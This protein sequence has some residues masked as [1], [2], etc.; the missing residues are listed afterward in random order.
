MSTHLCKCLGH[1]QM[2]RVNILSSMVMGCLVGTSCWW[3][4]LISAQL[5]SICI[6]RKVPVL[7]HCT[8]LAQRFSVHLIIPW[9]QGPACTHVPNKTTSISPAWEATHRLHRLFRGSRSGCKS[10]SPTAYAGCAKYKASSAYMQ[11][12]KVETP[13]L[14]QSRCT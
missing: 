12:S 10:G 7:L 2:Y 11:C 8:L 1:L 6:R 13:D 4:V 9:V 5:P 14:E 3:P